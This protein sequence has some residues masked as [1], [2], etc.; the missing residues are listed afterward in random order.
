M[1]DFFTLTTTHD[2]KAYP[3]QLPVLHLTVDGVTREI[4]TAD[5]QA[6]VDH[7]QAALEKCRS[8]SANVAHY[9]SR[10]R[11][12]W[13]ESPEEAAAENRAYHQRIQA[14][15]TAR[16]EAENR[17]RSEEAAARN[18]AYVDQQ[19]AKRIARAQARTAR[20]KAQ[21]EAGK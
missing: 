5:A 14:E 17:R 2:P 16:A 20:I 15:E 18:K 8:I 19:E 21:Q 11:N 7:L 3:P 10:L 4:S 9:E 1:S 13:Y 6:L 12:G